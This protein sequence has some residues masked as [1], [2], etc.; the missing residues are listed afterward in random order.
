LLERLAEEQVC[1]DVCPTSNLQLRV[2]PSLSEH[3]LPKLLAAG[4]AVSLNA[5][6]PLVFGSGI[7]GEYEVARSVF[8]LDDAALAKIAASSIRASGAP[9]DLKRSALAGVD[10]WLA[11]T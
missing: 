6:D 10:Q 5:D 3:P 8:G 11:A 1:L 2:V 4:I 9:E 7:L